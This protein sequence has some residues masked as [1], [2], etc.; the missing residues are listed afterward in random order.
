MNICF[1]FVFFTLLAES[2][3]CVSRIRSPEN[4]SQALLRDTSHGM[5]HEVTPGRLFADNELWILAALPVFFFL[6]ISD[7]LFAAM[8]PY[9][10]LHSFLSLKH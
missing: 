1:F 9:H 6:F 3:V 8:V 2:C 10:S 7:Q 4:S 5:L